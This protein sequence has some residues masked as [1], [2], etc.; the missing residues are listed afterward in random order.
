MANGWGGYALAPPAG[1]TFVPGVLAVGSNA[2]GRL[3]VFAIQAADGSGTDGSVWHNWQLTPTD[4]TGWAGW[5]AI[6]GANANPGFSYPPAGVS[7]LGFPK[8]LVVALNDK[9]G[10]LEV[11]AI[12]S[13][14]NPWHI[15]QDPSTGTG[16][17]PWNTM[18]P[19]SGPAISLDVA[20]YSG[21]LIVVYFTGTGQFYDYQMTPAS[22]PWAA[23]DRGQA[24]EIPSG[25]TSGFYWGTLTAGAVGT[26]LVANDFSVN[27]LVGLSGSL[28]DWAG[29]SPGPTVTAAVGLGSLCPPSVAYPDEEWTAILDVDVYGNLAGVGGQN[30]IAPNQSWPNFTAYAGPAEE[31][32]QFQDG[33][34]AVGSLKSYQPPSSGGYLG[35]IMQY[36]MA[37]VVDSATQRNVFNVPILC[38]DYN[39]GSQQP[40]A[41]ALI[42]TSGGAVSA[43]AVGTNKDGRLEVFALEGANQC[44]H[45]WQNAAGTAP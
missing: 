12:D 26:I 44:S 23:Q 16:W 41:P 36:L 7:T 28:S 2:D 39:Q 33:V 6:N 5:V 13:D 32:T 20:S 17:S 14:G 30:F 40:F 15:W 45:W 31:Q 37:F 10:L 19:P 29:W 3:E 9:T 8:R 25:Q 21:Q 4:G 42:G 1:V 34:L 24:L 22:G 43:I 35:N 27:K 38:D 11:F 18:Q